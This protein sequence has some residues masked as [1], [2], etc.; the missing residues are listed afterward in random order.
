MS[1]VDDDKEIWK[2]A[3][4][5]ERARCVAAVEAVRKMVRTP[6]DQYTAELY[7][8]WLNACDEIL[9]AIQGET[10]EQGR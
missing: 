5:W 10:N 9:A 2:S 8:A 1:N 4:A 7:G 3:V 6:E